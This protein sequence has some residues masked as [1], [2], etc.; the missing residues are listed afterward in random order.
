MGAQRRSRPR[1]FGYKWNDLTNLRLAPSNGHAIS[2]HTDNIQQYYMM[3]FSKHS[4]ACSWC[5]HQWPRNDESIPKGYFEG[6]EVLLNS[7]DS[8]WRSMRDKTM[9]QQC[10]AW[11]SL[12]S[13]KL[14]SFL[15]NF[16]SWWSRCWCLKKLFSLTLDLYVFFKNKKSGVDRT[17]QS[18]SRGDL[19]HHDENS[20]VLV[21]DNNAALCAC[22][23]ISTP[24][25]T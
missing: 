5:A 11:K 19:W 22:H 6:C 24:A 16:F 4:K 8:T 15:G 10:I 18:C 7:Q 3:Q 14:L 1:L 25:V 13:Q 17:L 21:L 23:R 2:V 12:H 9:L 20:Y